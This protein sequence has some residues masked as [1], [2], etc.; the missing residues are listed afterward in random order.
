MGSKIKFGR[1]F[2][3][4]GLLASVATPALARAP[5]RSIRPAPRPT[6]V[7]KIAA[8]NVGETVEK[9]GL[10]GKI[11]FMVV[12]LDSGKTIES[13]TPL[14]AQPP[15]SVAKAITSIYAL[16]VLGGEH[17]FRTRLLATGPI[18]N[19]RIEGDLIL[20]GDGDP[21]LDT[22]ALG[23]LAKRLKDAGVIGITGKARIYAAALP[24]Q[25]SIDPGQ[26][27]HLGYN[28]S[29][30][31]L[32]LNYNRVFFEWKRN[33]NGFDVTMDARALKF[34]P[35]VLMSKMRVVERKSPVFTH[36]STIN[37]EEWTV[38]RR[39]LGKK[40]GRWL[41][42]R[43]PEYYAGEVFHTIA[44]SY[45]I[46][47]PSFG[48]VKTL[49]RSTVIAE[50]QSDQLS[51][52]LR[53]MM[54]FSTNL[55]AE[56]AG[57]SASVARGRNPGSLKS[58]G[59]EMAAWLKATHGA[60]HTKFRDHSGLGED[61]RMS[62]ADMVKVLSKQGWNGP[63]RALMKDI[64][65]RDANG[66]PIKNAPIKVWAKTGTL[67]FVS[68]LAGYIETPNGRRLAFAI[69]AADLPKRSKISKSQR[70]RPRGARTWNKQAKVLQ[71]QLIERWANL[72]G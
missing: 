10:S 5:K 70:E 68:S 71:Q 12:D 52:M 6:Y 4:A 24:Y 58:S 42:V 18:K 44:R 49:P 14:L 65:L 36:K 45:G 25:K 47:L 34:R 51:S 20:A 1:R 2:M 57:V 31:G 11:G 3:L 37:S 8:G 19:G 62:A 21:T 22:D 50:W 33:A 7:R 39:A 27:D 64:P 61:S 59:R 72:A 38:S 41:P 28:P 13:R 66:R 32:N 54:K 23:V 29:L 16:S 26:P 46:D 67:N 53:G 63:L 15:A 40:G 43:R 60:Q 9:A 48:V 30:S 55:I 56:A 17:R 35:R 69:F